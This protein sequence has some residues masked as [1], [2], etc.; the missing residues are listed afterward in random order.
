MSRPALPPAASALLA[1]ARIAHTPCGDGT[2]VWHAWGS[3]PPVVLLHGGSGSWTHWVRNIPALLQAGHS[4]WAPDLPGF[5][6]SASPPGGQDADVSVEPLAAGL[7]QL[8]PGPFDLVAF[9]FGTLVAVLL[10]ARTPRLRRLVLLGPPLV[11]LRTGRGGLALRDWRQLPPQ[12]QP[13]AHASNLRA[14][15]LHRPESVDAEAL[16][17]HALNVARDRMRSRRLVTTSLLA[18]TLARLTGPVWLL[19]GREDAFYRD[20]WP[21]LTDCRDRLPMVQRMEVIERAG[22]W[23]QYEEPAQTNAFLLRALGDV[24]DNQERRRQA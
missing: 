10:A 21:G 23:V 24:G 8:L 3:G 9:S 1:Q 4:V 15:M 12:E 2:L 11:P 6:D 14:V 20:A 16:A 5:G 19:F 7:Q 13:A 18:D 17:L 22:H